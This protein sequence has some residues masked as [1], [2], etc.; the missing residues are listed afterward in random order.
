MTRGR[1]LRIFMSESEDQTEKQPPNETDSRFPSGPWIGFWIQRGIGKHRM[2]LSL[3]F[4][5]GCLKGQGRDVVGTFA[6]DGSYDLK[7][8]RVIMTKQ[9]LGAHQVQYDGANNGDGLWIW[10]V[11]NIRSMRG[12]FHL[13]PEGQPDPTQ[14]HLE[15]EEPAP[16]VRIVESK[17][18]VTSDPV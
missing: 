2:S 11:W 15:A 13:W 3:Q 8:G 14:K 16:V 18:A 10:G 9:Y 6:F 17:E 1:D 5:D 12:G 7:S 4:V